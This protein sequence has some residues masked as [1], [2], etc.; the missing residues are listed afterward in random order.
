MA[1]E[2][3]SVS[4]KVVVVTG[5]TSGIGLMIARGFVQAGA[6][7]YVS[8]RS[9]DACAATAQELSEYGECTGIPADM[10]KAEGVAA[11]VAAVTERESQLDVLVN[12]AGA[13]WG[14]PID[15]YPA[16]GFD[17]VL[18]LNVR[19]PFELSVAFLPLLRASASAESPARIINITSI[20]GSVI[21][22]WENYAYPASKA[23]LNQLTKHLAWR[24]AREH[25][26]V[27]AI[28]PGPFPSKMIAF[29]QEDPE[30]W[31]ALERSVPLG[32]AGR[33]DD[34]AGAAIFLA[35]PASAYLTGVILPVDGGLSGAGSMGDEG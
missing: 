9:P 14:A 16:S 18:S 20:E 5:G 30:G 19:A 22:R 24:L 21:P 3:F 28:A 32:R 15:E 23:A 1:Q 11:L 33:P 27:N 12:N 2:L 25:I 34:A 10:S 4:G 35:S 17:K 29:A 26:A 8:S 7:V 6:R 13:T 31:A